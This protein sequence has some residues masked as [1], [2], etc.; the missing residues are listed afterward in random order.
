MSGEKDMVDKTQTTTE[1]DKRFNDSG[2]EAAL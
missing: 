2:M 1:N